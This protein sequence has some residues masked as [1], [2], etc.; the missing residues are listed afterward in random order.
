LCLT[1]LESEFTKEYSNNHINSQFTRI[2][3]SSWGQYLATTSG[4]IDRIYSVPLIY[5][6]S[7]FAIAGH[8][9]GHKKNISVW[10]FSSALVKD[11]STDKDSTKE[12]VSTFLATSGGDSTIAIWKTGSKEPFSLIRSAFLAGVN[13]IT[14]GL[15]GNLLFACSHDGEVMAVHFGQGWLGDFLT[16]KER[17]ET[18]L[19]NYGDMVYNEYRLNNSLNLIDPPPETHEDESK[20]ERKQ[21]ISEGK[22]AKKRI[23]PIVEK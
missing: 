12:Q 19:S 17:N 16:K 7:E 20:E 1:I 21:V 10:R 8:L 2:D 22:H 18:I 9:K 3:W 23:I 15:H 5:R 14:W 13:D 6:G 4:W 11:Y